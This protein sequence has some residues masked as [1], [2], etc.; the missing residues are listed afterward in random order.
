MSSNSLYLCQHFIN[1]NVSGVVPPSAFLCSCMPY[2]PLCSKLPTELRSPLPLHP[3]TLDIM[4]ANNSSVVNALSNNTPATPTTPPLLSLPPELIDM[5]AQALDKPADLLSFRA[6][7]LD[8]RNGSALAFC[9]RFFDQVPVNTSG[10]RS[11]FQELTEMLQSPNLPQAQHFATILAVHVPYAEQGWGDA[12]EMHKRLAPSPADFKRLLA[13][14]PNLEEFVLRQCLSPH[15]SPMVRPAPVLLRVLATPGVH[16]PRLRRLAVVNAHVDT[17]LLLNVLETHKHSLENVFLARV[18]PT[19]RPHGMTAWRE[20]LKA[21]HSNGVSSV[22][23]YTMAYKNIDGGK[24]YIQ[25]PEHIQTKPEADTLE[26]RE[27]RI[28]GSFIDSAKQAKAFLEIA[29]THFGVAV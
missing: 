18:L 20:I 8:L 29:L 12:S 3:K 26:T 22:K 16:L 5:V 21:I 28:G 10:S 13:A 19:G 9:R 15:H 2:K 17:D 27:E 6:T 14:M 25:F 4:S 1:H 11:S 7:C 24:R 23:L